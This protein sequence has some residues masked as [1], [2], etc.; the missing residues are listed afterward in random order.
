MMFVTHLPCLALRGRLGSASAR[1]AQPRCVSEPAARTASGGRAK[2]ATSPCR[3]A[4]RRSAR[5][6]R[7]R[8]PRRR[9][10][11]PP[12]GTLPAARR[13]PP[14]DRLSSVARVSSC[15]GVRSSPRGPRACSTVSLFDV[16]RVPAVV[17][18]HVA[19][20]VVED[21][22]QPRLQV[23]AALKLR[24]RPERLEIR[25]LDQVLRILRPARQPQRRPVQAVDVRQRLARERVA[26]PAGQAAIGTPGRLSRSEPGAAWAV[27]KRRRAS[28][29]RP[30]SRED[31]H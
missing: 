19:K 8:T 2:S 29:E 10:A 7:T 21:R 24:G 11:R 31:A 27:G 4:R 17:P 3:S 30:W 5:S 18:A 9:A 16:D 23:R 13:A 28:S 14:A 25:V 1:A 15:S 12:D 20:R 6:R 22:E 26:A